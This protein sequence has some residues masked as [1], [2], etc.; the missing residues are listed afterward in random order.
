MLFYPVFAA[1]FAYID[2]LTFDL[3]RGEV[4][5]VL[6]AGKQLY[7]MSDQGS[8]THMHIQFTC[9]LSL[10]NQPQPSHQ[11]RDREREKYHS[12]QFNHVYFLL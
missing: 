12:K 8:T 4:V 9:S 11:Y 2:F 7:Q 3:V 5:L 6:D 1:D 10:L